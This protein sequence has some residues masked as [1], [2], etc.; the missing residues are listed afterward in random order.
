MKILT[1]GSFSGGTVPNNTTFSGNVAITGTLDVT[2]VAT[3]TT[4]VTGSGNIMAGAAFALGFTGRGQFKSSADGIIKAFFADGTT[5]AV[6]HAGPGA[7]TLPGFAFTNNTGSGVWLD[8]NA[9]LAFSQSGALCHYTNSPNGVG[10]AIN[11]A[12]DLGW[13]SAAGIQNCDTRLRRLSAGLVG[14]AGA[15]A[16]GAGG[17]QPAQSAN[18][19]TIQMLSASE[20]LTLSTSGTTTDTTANLLP[21]GAIIHTVVARITTT[22][23]TATSWQLGDPTT[24]GRFTAANSTMTANTTDI[25]TVHR[26][27]GVAS[28]TTG[29]I[30]TAAAKVRVT[31][32]GTPGAGVIRIT[33][34]YT[35]LT[36]PTS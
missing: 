32:V 10:L 13:G 11:S 28:A 20:S 1:L 23:T 17:I 35:L 18:G 34:F 21:A 29:M 6:V 14:V 33:V 25:G 22:I 9:Y 5:G 15:S 2:G 27:T 31:T 3:F 36:P 8:Q 30:Q 26:T 12:L 7:V 16:T 24:A 4:T 19:A